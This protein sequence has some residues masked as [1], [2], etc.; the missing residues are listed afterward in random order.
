MMPI[1][2]YKGVDIHL[3]LDTGASF[4]FLPNHAWEA[5]DTPLYLSAT[6]INKTQERQFMYGVKE[7][8]NFGGVSL[9]VTPIV[10]SPDAQRPSLL[11]VDILSRID[12]YI[13]VHQGTLFAKPFVK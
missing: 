3:L 8:M 1:R 7:S 10:L 12:L 11:G 13:N 5:S 9:E 4:T 6:D 2:T